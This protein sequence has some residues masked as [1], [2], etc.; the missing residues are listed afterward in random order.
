M[1]PLAAP[2]ASVIAQTALIEDLHRIAVWDRAALTAILQT[3][4]STSPPPPFSA[5]DSPASTAL[6]CS[7]WHIGLDPQCFADLARDTVARGAID[8][9]RT[10]ARMLMAVDWRLIGADARLRALHVLRGDTSGDTRRGLVWL[11]GLD[12]DMPPWRRLSSVGE[13][14][15]W[16]GLRA[17]STYFDRKD[18][19][20][21]RRVEAAWR[22]DDPSALLRAL[23]ALAESAVARGTK[24]GYAVPRLLLREIAHT[25]RSPSALAFACDRLAEIVR[26]YLEYA[27][28]PSEIA[29]C[30]RATLG[31]LLEAQ[32][33]SSGDDAVRRGAIV[34][35]LMSA[36]RDGLPGHALAWPD[37]AFPGLAPPPD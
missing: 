24:I 22:T 28:D 23:A 17:I 27:H 36:H 30:H 7:Q 5:A 18:A 4:F 33:A 12:G 34:D 1:N 15:H 35:V 11:T 10:I 16:L 2:D 21:L 26:Q 20:L 31:F 19:R 37:D 14:I 6:Y 29:A 9:D 8:S 25:T 3:H 13:R 32:S